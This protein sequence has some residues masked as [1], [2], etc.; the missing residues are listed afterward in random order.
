MTDTLIDFSVTQYMFCAN[1]N[2][3][4][5]ILNLYVYVIEHISGTGFNMRLFNLF[6]VLSFPSFLLALRPIPHDDLFSR[7]LIL[8]VQEI[9]RVSEPN[10]LFQ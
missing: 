2:N 1:I 9:L 3:V 5:L 6:L 8:E 7:F 4:F 10:H